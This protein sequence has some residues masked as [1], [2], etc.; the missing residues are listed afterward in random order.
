MRHEDR[1]HQNDHDRNYGY[2]RAQ[3]LGA[4]IRRAAGF[5]AVAGG[6]CP[7][8]GGDLRG[9]LRGHRLGLDAGGQVGL[10]GDRRQPVATPDQWLLEC[11]FQRGNVE[12]RQVAP[13]RK[14]QLQLPQRVERSALVAARS[15]DHIDE[16][17]VIA[18]LGDDETAR[19]CVDRLCESL[20]ADPETARLVLV[21]ID[22]HGLD[23]LAP[24]EPDLS[25][26]GVR[27][28]D[29]GDCI[30]E[31]ANFLRLGAAYPV[32]QW[33]ADR[34]PQFERINPRCDVGQGGRQSLLQP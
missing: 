9:Q 17:D 14:G 27:S 3:P 10:D 33:P 7:R 19:R 34:R 29:V 4:R 8:E 11:A 12:K 32:L 25:R 24:I 28:D 1:R 31:V 6:Q 20:R 23:G 13:A 2:D 18:Q 15:G 5:D 26:P 22:V 21:D 30:G 16:I